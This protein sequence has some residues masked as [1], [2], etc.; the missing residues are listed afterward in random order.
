MIERIYYCDGPDCEREWRKQAHRELEMP[1]IT[2]AGP[3]LHFCGWDC[4]LK[5]AATKEPEIIVED[6]NV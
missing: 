6:P 5:F 4:V 1:V 2:N 3:T